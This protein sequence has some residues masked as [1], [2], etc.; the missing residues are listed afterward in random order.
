MNWYKTAQE[1]ERWS[2][3]KFLATFT[4]TVIAGLLALNQFGM[5]DLQKSY[6]ENPQQVVQEARQVQEQVQPISEEPQ[7]PMAESTSQV[8]DSLKSMIARHE[9][10]ENTVYQDTEG[11][12]TIGIGFN[13][14]RGDASE[15]LSAL[16]LDINDVLQGKA[17]TDEQ[18]D[19]LFQ[20]DVRMTLNDARAFLPNFDKQPEIVQDI[21]IDMSFNLGLTRLSQ[22]KNFRKALSNSDYQTAAKE[23]VDSRWYEQVGNR[24]KE[25]VQMMKEVR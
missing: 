24:S 9:G 13:L 2:W 25:L 17:L 20:D 11:V 16:G 14:R 5:L 6:A 7:P 4:P 8:S 15:K 21:I 10:Y 22:F 12:P 19:S 1:N 3:G 23:M 18:I